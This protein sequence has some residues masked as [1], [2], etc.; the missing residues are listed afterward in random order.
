MNLVLY[1][2]IIHKYI[3]S[4]YLSGGVIA[5]EVGLGKTLQAF[6]HILMNIEND[7]INR[8]DKTIKGLN[9]DNNNLVILPSRLVSQWYDE[10]IKYIK[11]NHKDYI[12][13]C[14][15]CSIHDI[16]KLDKLPN[17]TFDVYII[18]SMIFNNDNYKLYL[19][20]DIDDN[21]TFHKLRSTVSRK[22]SQVVKSSPLPPNDKMDDMDIYNYEKAISESLK[23]PLPQPTYQID[24]NEILETLQSN[25]NK[26]PK[27]KS[28]IRSLYTKTID[29]T[30]K[31]ELTN[32]IVNMLDIL[33]FT[34]IQK[35]LL[36][37]YI[38][39]INNSD[40]GNKVVSSKK[41]I[42][43]KKDT[44]AD[45]DDD[46]AVVSINKQKVNKFNIYK[47]KWNRI[48][49]DEG[50]EKLI[51]SD[52]NTLVDKR[53]CNNILRL[54]SNYK[55]VIT[56]TP[57]EKGIDNLKGITSFLSS[58]KI[59]ETTKIYESN[60]V[61][62]DI[63]HRC[64]LH[65]RIIDGMD[66]D[67]LHKLFRTVFRKNTKK[68]VNNEISIPLFSQDITFLTQTQIERNIYLESLRLNDIARLFKL[69]THIQVS[70]EDEVFSSMGDILSLTDI[71][72][73][74]T[75]KFKI[76]QLELID[77]NKNIQ[78]SIN[79]NLNIF[80]IFEKLENFILKPIL[81]QTNNTTSEE[82]KKRIYVDYPVEKR[83]LMRETYTTSI[84]NNCLRKNNNIVAFNNISFII[85]ILK[86]TVLFINDKSD[87]SVNSD[88][89][90]NSDK[91]D[92]IDMNL[93]FTDIINDSFHYMN[94][95]PLINL[96]N[97]KIFVLSL[98]CN[99]LKNN[100]ENKLISNRK[101][102]EANDIEIK[103]LEN[104]MIQFTRTDYVKETIND[105]CGICFIDFEKCCAITSCRHVFCNECHQRLMN[106][107]SV[108][109]K[110]IS[111]PFCRTSLLKNIDINIVSIDSIKDENSNNIK[112]INSSDEIQLTPEEILE[113]TKKNE[114]NTQNINKY[115]T[116][117][118]YL[119]K[120]LNET[121][122]I[123][124]SARVI[125]FSQYDRMLKLIGGVLKEH[126]IEHIFLK[127][128]THTITKNV[129]KFK[130]DINIRVIM[131]SSETCAS[132]SN[133]T[134]ASHIVFADVINA[135][136][137]QS[138]DI[139]TQAIGRA[140][141]LGQSK[142]VIVKRLI[143]SNTVEDEYYNKN[144]Y[145]IMELQ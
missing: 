32:V 140:V 51:S 41:K 44:V 46:I 123:D 118:A 84:I 105:P 54:Q 28:Y 24:Q 112:A 130:E 50:H 55:W 124:A 65:N 34:N 80:T 61:N 138:R 86:N 70:D 45:D 94:I 10:F 87:N 127:G 97:D 100:Y 30:Q 6:T 16:K 108:E 36:A 136:A 3:S 102:F 22:K 115:G 91:N 31:I 129:R 79:K 76:L 4:V 117:L 42:N 33:E 101:S 83:I 103:R 98:I 59:S 134:E 88:N 68:A 43:T 93:H 39:N 74:L 77:K 26:I 116:K 111:C 40:D 144:K 20:D 125:I 114:L 60:L 21:S 90:D 48:W 131:L 106:S 38:R 78:L 104:V 1:D 53:I 15:I 66:E 109:T 12:K 135:E 5:D 47:K 96:N 139:E 56:A 58:M 52:T 63:E 120:Y 119:I 133:L 82:N 81:K 18:S 62:T 95:L 110:C 73:K 122:F 7:K 13:V 29:L 113:N 142:S 92:N 2:T 145:D 19:N 8:K 9:Y 14:K 37:L 128:S 132:G 121:V 25:I 137:S 57:L 85:E 99:V 143:M 89:S 67:E 107:V 49:I 141:R 17:N 71:N 35:D 23:Q 75:K 126:S 11:S 64:E 72:D 27:I 69:C